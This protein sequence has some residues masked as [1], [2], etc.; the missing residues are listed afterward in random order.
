MQKAISISLVA[1]LLLNVMGYYG[2]F[3][4]LKYKNAVRVTSQ[5][6]ARDYLESETVTIKIPL[7]VPYYGDTEFERVDGEIEHEGQFY[8]LVKQKLAKDTLHVVCIR[9]TRA[10]HIHEVLADYVNTFTDQSS[11]RSGAKSIQSFIKD[12]FPSTFAL[13]EAANGWTVSLSY[14]DPEIELSDPFRTFP[15]PPPRV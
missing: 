2:F 10:K 3:I 8:R 6:E 12:Y 5:I 14:C 1:L 7:S 4:G 13:R 15:S 9:D 11:D